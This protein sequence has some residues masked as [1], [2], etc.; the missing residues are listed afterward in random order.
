MPLWCSRF[1]P[2]SSISPVC[3]ALHFRVLTSAKTTWKFFLCNHYPGQ[4]PLEETFPRHTHVRSEEPLHQ[5]PW[6]SHASLQNHLYPFIL[7]R[8]LPRARLSGLASPWMNALSLHVGVPTHTAS[9]WKGSPG[10]R[11]TCWRKRIR[12]G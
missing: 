3:H 1:L 4:F 10:V 9:P 12:Y 8:H 7:P 5:P 2:T 11:L 6:D